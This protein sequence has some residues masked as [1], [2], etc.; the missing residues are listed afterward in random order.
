MERCALDQQCLHEIH[1]IRLCIDV[2]LVWTTHDGVPFKMVLYWYSAISKVCIFLLSL[3]VVCVMCDCTNRTISQDSAC[4]VSSRYE[5][6]VPWSCHV[7][8]PDSFTSWFHLDPHA[9]I[10][11]VGR[12]SRLLLGEGEWE[13]EEDKEKVDKLLMKTAYRFAQER[14]AQSAQGI[15]KCKGWVQTALSH[16]VWLSFMHVLF[17]SRLTRAPESR[18][19]LVWANVRTLCVWGT[20]QFLFVSYHVARAFMKTSMWYVAPCRSRTNAPLRSLL[21]LLLLWKSERFGTGMRSSWRNSSKK[22]SAMNTM[23]RC[24]AQKLYVTPDVWTFKLACNYQHDLGMQLDLSRAVQI[25]CSSMLLMHSC[26][27]GCTGLLDPVI[28]PIE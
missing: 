15:P 26:S 17:L 4:C 9:S 6:C 22:S 5:R 11:W 2:C 10:F 21:S 20:C 18:N 25:N 28:S 3:H 1:R 19:Y 14:V 27:W 24:I 13:S 12:A 23:S 8:H 7:E 16:H